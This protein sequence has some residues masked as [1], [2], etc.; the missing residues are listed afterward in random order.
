[1][2]KG[3]AYVPFRIELSPI[4][5]MAMFHFHKNPDSEYDAFELH[6][7]ESEETG[8]G[9]RVLAWRKDGYRD[10]YV[11]DS[12]TIK[13]EDEILAVG[14][15]G[16]KERFHVR[17]DEA[18]FNHVNGRLDA[19]FVFNDK[20]DRRIVLYVDERI[21]KES[22]PLTWLPSVGNHIKEPHSMP[23]FFLY[24]FDFARKRDTD[25]FLS[26]DGIVKEVDPFVF[27]KDFQSRYYVEFS[28]NSV[29][30]SFNKAG[31]YTLEQVEI[32]EQGVAKTDHH[33]YLYENDEGL[34]K[35]K[36]MT[37]EHETHPVEVSFSPVFPNHKE[38]IEAKPFYGE[39]T[40]RPSGEAGFL[41]GKY[42]VLYQRG[43]AII[44]LTFPESWQTPKGANYERFINS[45]T[46]NIKSWYQTYQC[47][48]VVR[49]EDMDTR[50]EWTRVDSDRRSR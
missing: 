22:K 37:L 26:I 18:Y 17:F 29:V 42:N 6:Y 23:L 32:D 35:L 28:T 47:R 11:Q 40:I 1:M 16:L 50:I 13:E 9:F 25:I 27:P 48:Q 44:N 20:H 34:Y 43:K 41:K 24:D 3:K 4:K 21:E 7:I 10:S 36:R 39:F 30:A 2:S 45:M 19:G 15:K 12:L 31:K 8:S 49:L 33:T 5:Q 14:G 46:P 38:V